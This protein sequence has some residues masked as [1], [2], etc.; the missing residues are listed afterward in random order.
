[1]RSK[2]LYSSLL[3]CLSFFI[4]SSM[5]YATDPL[6][7]INSAIEYIDK[8]DKESRKYTALD[9]MGGGMRGREIPF[10]EVDQL[11]DKIIESFRN[12]KGHGLRHITD[13]L[14]KFSVEEELIK[15][16]SKF[17]SEKKLDQHK[18]KTILTSKGVHDSMEGFSEL[19]HGQDPEACKEFIRV[20]GVSLAM[21]KPEENYLSMLYNGG[22]LTDNGPV[23]ANLAF[24]TSPIRVLEEVPKDFSQAIDPISLGFA[25][26]FIVDKKKDIDKIYIPTFSEDLSNLTK[27]RAIEFLSYQMIRM[28]GDKISNKWLDYLENTLD[29]DLKNSLFVIHV[30]DGLKGAQHI[31]IDNLHLYKGD[32][33]D[34]STNR[35][36]LSLCMNC[37]ESEGTRVFDLKDAEID[38]HVMGAL[39]EDDL[40]EAF[41]DMRIETDKVYLT[42][43]KKVLSKR[44]DELLE[45]HEVEIASKDM[46]KYDEFWL[47]IATTFMDEPEN[48]SKELRIT[49]ARWKKKDFFSTQLLEAI[50]MEIF[51][52]EN[53]KMYSLPSIRVKPNTPFIMNWNTAHWGPARRTKGRVFLSAE[54]YPADT[55]LLPE[56]VQFNLKGFRKVDQD[57]LKAMRGFYDPSK[58]IRSELFAAAKEVDAV[59]F[60]KAVTTDLPFV[61]NQ[62]ARYLKVAS[63]W[64]LMSEKDDSGKGL[65]DYVFDSLKKV[66]DG[67]K[68]RG[69]SHRK[70]LR[71]LF[72][73]G[74]ELEDRLLNEIGDELREEIGKYYKICCPKF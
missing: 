60:R 53:D 9:Q 22:V 6:K 56:W 58:G 24:N 31:H 67:F 7:L 11:D 4:K 74:V 46:D 28:W 64:R 49:I 34:Q 8:V 35:Q 61:I 54:F 45:E 42:N 33:L 27:Y 50:K 68:F 14:R 41:K 65:I 25:N 13:A 52:F 69:S 29:L 55:S 5:L 3:V 43:R 38:Y 47:E 71:F 12:I 72:R 36:M 19:F 59:K 62:N 30:N 23:K 40:A 21:T 48:I 51:H 32:E 2:E 20:L 63:S 18:L 39:G 70:I 15:R 10:E 44:I 66:E 57:I 37:H 26:K 17:C 1:M 73:A 16:F